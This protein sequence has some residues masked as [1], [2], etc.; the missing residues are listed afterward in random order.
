[1]KDI[2]SLKEEKCPCGCGFPLMSYILGRS[3]DMM[4]L[5]AAN[6][7]PSQ[8][9]DAVSSISELTDKFQFIVGKRGL[10]DHATIRVEL[11]KGAVASEDFQERLI[12]QMLA[13]ASELYHA[14]SIAKT[15]EFPEVELVPYGTFTT[16]SRFKFKRF[17][18]NRG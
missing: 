1:M 12:K 11:R 9:M 17:I 15:I 13:S 8:V 3:D 16:G 2:I 10:R 18:D 4:T 6:V 14:T 5:G 7:Y